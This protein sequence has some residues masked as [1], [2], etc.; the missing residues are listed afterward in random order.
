MAIYSLLVNRTAEEPQV[1][2]G[3]ANCLSND[4][5]VTALPT[6]CVKTRDFFCN[7]VEGRPLVG[8]LKEGFG[9]REE[10]VLGASHTPTHPVLDE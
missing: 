3:D 4:L 2:G 10:I 8:V 6:G 7:L 1:A 5:R 9:D